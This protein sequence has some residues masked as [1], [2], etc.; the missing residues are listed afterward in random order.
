VANAISIRTHGASRYVFIRGSV[1][2]ADRE[3]QGASALSS[4]VPSEDEEPSWYT[5]R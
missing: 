3:T 5:G 1:L 2:H 4:V